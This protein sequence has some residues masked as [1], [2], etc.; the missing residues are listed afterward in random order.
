[1]KKEKK[2]KVPKITHIMA[3]GSIQD[4]IEGYE[5]PV[6]DNTKIAYMLLAKWIKGSYERRKADQ[7]LKSQTIYS[8]VDR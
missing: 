4:S 7:N 5:V 1:M 6:N 2:K 3:N 8:C